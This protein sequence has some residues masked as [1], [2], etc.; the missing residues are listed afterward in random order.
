MHDDA[1]DTLAGFQITGGKYAT[2]VEMLN[3]R[4]DDKEFIIHNHY[5]A[6]STLSRCKDSTHNLRH[7]FNTTEN[8]LRSLESLGEQVEGNQYTFPEFHNLVL[9]GHE[10]EAGIDKNV[11]IVLR[12]CGNTYSFSRRQTV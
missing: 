12:L 1:K 6:L 4:Y 9:K 3:R 11:N 10:K 2:A 7:T 8:H 5:E